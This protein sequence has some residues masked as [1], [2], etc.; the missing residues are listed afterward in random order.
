MR[1]EDYDPTTCP[2]AGCEYE[3]S[4]RSV[5]AHISGTDDDRHAWENLVFESARDFVMREK[6]RQHD[7]TTG[8]G[9]SAGRNRSGD[10]SNTSG[11]STASPATETVASTVSDDEL[12]ELDLGF[13]RDALVLLDLVRQYD[14]D[15]LGELD[16]FRLV[17]LYTLLSDVGRGADDA[18]KQVRDVLL[19]V[20]QDDRR[21]SSDFG[22]VRRYTTRRRNQKDEA[23][24]RAELERSGIDPREAMSFDTTKLK[25]FAE[26]RGLD[27]SAVFD[28]EDRT[29]VK[30]S[31]ADGDGRRRAFEELDPEIRSLVEK[32]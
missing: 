13:A 29:Y 28:H 11:G 6:R 23:V 16:T 15:S 8:S 4:I 25:Q 5:A 7:E 32:W 1:N 21:V 26:E 2:A 18:R 9:G 22:S 17:N 3:D 19:D 31:G 24:I 10:G 30:K 27:E 12:P 14:A 20:L